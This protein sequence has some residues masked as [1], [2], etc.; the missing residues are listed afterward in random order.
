MPNQHWLSLQTAAILAP[1]KLLSI[2]L[3]PLTASVVW[4]QTTEIRLP[5]YPP[6]P[7]GITHTSNNELFIGY[8]GKGVI[9]QLDPLTGKTNV[10][11]ESE[12]IPGTTALRYDGQRD[13]LWAMVPPVGSISFDSKAGLT[14]KD[15]PADMGL[16]KL[17]AINNGNVVKEIKFPQGAFSN[18]MT[19]GP[20]GE[21]F[22]TDSRNPRIYRVD[23]E[24]RSIEIYAEDAALGSEHV[25]LAGIDRL[26]D[27][28]LI[29]GNF[30]EGTLHRI[31]PDR[32]IETV[33]LPR[34]LSFPDGLVRLDDDRL[35]VTE[36]ATTGGKGMITLVKLHRDST[37]TLNGKLH[38][39]ADTLDTPVNLTLLDKTI[40][41]TDARVR[42][43]FEPKLYSQPDFFRIVRID[44]SSRSAVHWQ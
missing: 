31:S 38:V 19:I 10:V 9:H 17:I 44:L 2:L 43:L 33:Q 41:A 18:D 7:N 1:M 26:P 42:H 32:Q 36:G 29:V 37:G 35:V 5:D 20:A 23:P 16:T 14:W 28:S 3:L 27:G 25:G 12:N 22:V 30:A 6:Y 8:V 4:A 15:N 21:I 13:W 34:K 11:F 40:F 39:L 24:K